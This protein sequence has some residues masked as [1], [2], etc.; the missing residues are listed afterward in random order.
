MDLIKIGKYIAGKRRGLG[1][2]QKQVAEKLGMSDKYVSKWERG[3]CLP[4]VS[5]YIE[6]CDILHISI[7]E[8]LAGEDI[9]QENIIRKSEDNV[10]QVAKDSNHRQKYLKRIIVVLN[11]IVAAAVVVLGS[12]AWGYLSRPKNYISPVAKDSA[13]M[14]TAELLSGTDGAFLFRYFARDKYK[15]LTIYVSEYHCGKLV[16]KSK[17]AVFSAD[18]QLPSEGMVAIVPDF[19]N[20]TV[21]LILADA[22]SKFS[23]DISILEGVENRRYYGRSASQIKEETRIEY[24]TEQ[25]LKCRE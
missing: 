7:H 20:F 10:I 22:C 23:T 9:D 16:N 18:A 3:I 8:F 5:V 6:L 14:K 12:I 19:E 13:E 17:A 24:D 11:M 1:L 2:T 4:D 15:E 21:K 25:E